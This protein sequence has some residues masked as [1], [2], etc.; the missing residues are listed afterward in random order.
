MTQIDWKEQ[1]KKYWNKINSARKEFQEF[2]N[3]EWNYAVHISFH[4]NYETETDNI[5]RLVRAYL[6]E[7]RRNRK[8]TFSSFYIIPKSFIDPK[9]NP[10]HIHILMLIFNDQDRMKILL[11]DTSAIFPSINK[12]VVHNLYLPEAGKYLT[13]FENLNLIDLDSI[14]FDFYREKLLE[15]YC[16]PTAYIN[17]ELRRR[18]EIV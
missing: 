5:N 14:Y 12:C 13:T 7:L 10:H 6:N 11:K 17:D 1:N 15:K 18:F 9:F 8:L 3:Y 2:I 16:N 4:K